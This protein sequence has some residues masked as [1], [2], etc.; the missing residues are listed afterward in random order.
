[1]AHSNLV[2]KIFFGAVLWTIGFMTLAS[3]ASHK[4]IQE[5]P[6]ILHK[7]SKAIGLEI[8]D[9]NIGFHF[10][11]GSFTPAKG[12]WEFPVP[13]EMI[14]IKTVA[15]DILISASGADKVIITATGELDSS[16]SEALLET[17]MNNGVL[18]IKQDEENSRNVAIHIQV[19]TSY[20]KK[21]DVKSVSG[22]LK[23]QGVALGMLEIKSISGDIQADSVRANEVQIKSVSGDINMQNL[24][25]GPIEIS[26]ISG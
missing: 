13:E 21:L 10:N 26:T 25:L 2:V 6:Q 11:D 7:I 5:D 4:A 3:F 19:P 22:D 20:S 9:S 17:S 15:A 23:L 8:S 1:M 24:Q 12:D 16:E 14:E 18:E